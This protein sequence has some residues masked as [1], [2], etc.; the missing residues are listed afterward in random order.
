GLL[1]TLNELG[2]EPTRVDA[3]GCGGG[4]N[5]KDGV[6][7]AVR[8]MIDDGVDVMFPLLNVI[9]LPGYLSE[10]TT[11][12]VKPGDIQFYNTDYNAQSGDLAS[13]K[14]VA[15][16]GAEAGALYNKAEIISSGATGDFRRPGFTPS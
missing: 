11:Q 6:I 7:E 1:D 14:V 12:G 8:G 16:G 2:I 4:N 3:I 9:S 5:C 13:S 15:F 10:M